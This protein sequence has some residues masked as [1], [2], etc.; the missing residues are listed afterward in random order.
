MIELL[1]S[2][3]RLATPLLFASM[4]GLLCERAGVA[5]ICLEG[6]MLTSAWTAAVVN[7]YTHNAWLAVTVAL[8]V[9]ALTMGIH[10]FLTITARADQIISGVVVN[11]LAA[12]ITPLLTNAFF[13]APTNTP[14]IPL[15]DRFHSVELWGL[16]AIPGLGKILFAH[17]PL[18][19]LALLLPFA[20]HF[21]VYRKGMGLRLLAS[22]DGPE[23]LRTAGV[24][25]GRVRYAALLLGGAI[26]SLGGT[27]LSISHTSQFT[28]DMTAGRGFIALTALIFG[29][30]RPVPTFFACLFFGFADALQIQLQSAT[31][32][33]VQF[34]VQF[35]QALP[36]LVTIVV[37]VGFIGK[38]IPPLS[39]GKRLG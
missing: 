15:A 26:T 35:I 38:A 23:A 18:I 19:Y 36:Y 9:G 32:F 22:G 27:F 17:P 13:G 20:V 31:V 25:P 28:R 3:I 1:A 29:K 7:Y 33:G 21:A 8:W 4:G 6:V 39:I 37:L 12:G 11:F 10:A 30:W 16:S 24:S 34:P 2:S 5:T 14:S